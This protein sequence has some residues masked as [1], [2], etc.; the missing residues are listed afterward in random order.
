V[1][2]ATAVECES[3]IARL[4]RRGELSGKRAGDAVARLDLLRG[5]WKVIAPIEAV[6]DEAIRL[7]RAYD[8]R[9]ADALQIAAAFVAS[10]GKPTAVDVVTLDD[11]LA[12]A[13]RAEGF[14]IVGPGT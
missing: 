5:H 2:W 13:A 7:V 4:R 12:A 3:A 1:W 8:L 6:R 14:R 9:A 11:R 10:E